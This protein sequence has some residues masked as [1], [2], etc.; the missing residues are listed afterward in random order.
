MVIFVSERQ[1]LLSSF[2]LHFMHLGPEGTYVWWKLIFLLKWNKWKFPFSDGYLHYFYKQI[3]NKN[4]QKAT[5]VCL[6]YTSRAYNPSEQE[7]MVACTMGSCSFSC[8]GKKEKW[9][10]VL[11]LQPTLSS[12]QGHNPW[13]GIRHI[14]AR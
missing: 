8:T 10:P 3:T 11:S 13:K 5:R 9:M 4:R 14:Q 1:Y 6:D 2:L 12:I 7:Y